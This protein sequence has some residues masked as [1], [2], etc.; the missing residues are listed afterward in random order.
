MIGR[1]TE[2]E[3][4]R[5]FLRITEDLPQEESHLDLKIWDSFMETETFVVNLE[6]LE[7]FEHE[8]KRRRHSR[9]RE[10]SQRK[11]PWE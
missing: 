6:E 9:L 1:K 10:Q 7:A 4:M 3:G 11:E 8:D 5:T 2:A